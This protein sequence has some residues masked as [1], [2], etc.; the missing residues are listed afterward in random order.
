MSLRK[1]KKLERAFYLRD[2][3][4]VA[5]EL[6]GKNLI[7]IYRDKSLQ[8]KIVE[9][10]AY[11]QN[12]PA[13]HSYNG[14]TKRNEVMFYQGGHLYVYFTYGM[15]YCCNVVT[16][17]EGSGCAVLI[18][19]I[20]PVENIEI[21]KRLRNWNKEKN[22]YDL[23]NG[24]AKVCQALE[25]TKKENGTDL[26]GDKIFIIDTNEKVFLEDIGVSSR[27]GIRNGVNHKWRFFLKNSPWISK[28]KI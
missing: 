4:T 18:R 13:S 15:H 24:P 28:T 8:G 26:C 21:M 2:T 23:T 12:D 27:I 10:E 16:E 25:I 22:I 1:G 3:I 20:E 7:R 5:R 6:L 11:T 17:A 19:A 14:K 9:V